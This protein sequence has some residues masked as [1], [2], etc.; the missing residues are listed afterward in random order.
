MAGPIKGTVGWFR[1]TA[2]ALD[3]EIYAIS[4]LIKNCYDA[5]AKIVQLN[6]EGA[7]K[8]LGQKPSFYI[9]DDG[10]GMSMEDIHKKWFVIGHSVNK[11]E[12]YSPGGRIRQGGKGIGRLGSWKIGE[13][14]TVY[15]SKKGHQP[16]GIRIDISTLQSSALLDEIDFQEV[17]GA[18][19]FFP[20]GEY[21]TIILVEEFNAKLTSA[22]QFCKNMSRN[23][24][25]LQNP[26]EGLANFRINPLYPADI[27]EGMK[28]FNLPSLA[29]NGLYHA[30]L[31]IRGNQI[32]GL[33]VNNNP[34]SDD[35]EDT[36]E[37]LEVVQSEG[38]MN[39]R[40]IEIKIRAFGNDS[41]YKFTRTLPGSKQPLSRDKFQEVTGFR[42]YK[43]G[44][45][46]LP[47]GAKGDDWLGL[48][49][50]YTKRADSIFRSSQ[51]IA[52]ANYNSELNPKLSEV[53]SRNGLVNNS[54]SD[55]LKKCLN[56][57]V[58]RLR[59]WANQIPR[60]IPDK[61]TAPK[62]HYSLIETEPGQEFV[63]TQPI[64]SGGGF[65]NVM[66]SKALNVKNQHIDSSSGV[67]SGIAPQEP[68][69]YTIE[70]HAENDYGE[71]NPIIKLIVNH[72]IVED[73]E[74]PNSGIMSDIVNDGK[75]HDLDVDN[76]FPPTVPNKIIIKNALTQSLGTLRGVLPQLEGDEKV[77]QIQNII[78]SI[79]ELIDNMDDHHSY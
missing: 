67:I 47:Y 68:G 2:N 21:G 61:F 53:A 23:I 11:K 74:F 36:K 45:R 78:E 32:E 5:D 22:S 49:R 69:E 72:P 35:Y 13:K 56:I 60:T 30:N 10:H 1:E 3:S 70:L 64:N 66:I 46:V 51:I 55:Y 28:D 43:N 34:Y 15:T 4:E 41:I 6:L 18:G 48:D 12:R 75:D 73:D 63:S 42:L 57:A 31:T 40:D 76:V 39:L 20:R 62:L 58:K 27:A 71:S 9:K 17:S 52:M 79:Q 26:F 24:L 59:A 50:E 77:E 37:F 25:L 14:V 54:S 8:P 65:I 44:I 7:F 29:E 38:E 16:L 33:F 19:D